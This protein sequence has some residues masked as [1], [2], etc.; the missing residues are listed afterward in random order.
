MASASIHIMNLSHERY[1][2]ETKSMSSHINVGSGLDCS[3]LDLAE[4]IARSCGL[5]RR[6]KFDSSKPDGVPRKLLDNS[7]INNLGWKPLISLAD[8]LSKTYKFYLDEQQ[9]LLDR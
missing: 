1:L 4:L 9:Q 5:Q 8:G 2:K 6:N 7:C 3:I